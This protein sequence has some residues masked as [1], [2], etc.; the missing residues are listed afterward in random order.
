MNLEDLGE[1]ALIERIR[2]QIGEHGEGV[3]IGIGDDAA[4]LSPSPGRLLLATTDMLVEGVDFKRSYA[5][6]RQIGWKALA[7]NLSD[8]AAMGGLPR[9]ALVSLGLPETTP[10][11][12]VDELYEGLTAIAKAH[13]VHIVGGD[14]GVAPVLTLSITLIGEVEPGRLVRRSGARV[15]DVLAVTGSLGASA[16]G[17]AILNRGKGDFDE[18][19]ELIHAH[20]RPSPRVIEGAI[21]ARLGVHAMIDL[22]D[23]LATD[24]DH[25]CRASGVGGRVCLSQLP[26][27][28]GVARAAAALGAEPWRLAVSGGEDFE[29]LFALPSH[30]VPGWLVELERETGT[31]A[32]AIGEVVDAGMRVQ[33]VN[34]QGESV[35]FGRGFEHFSQRV[36]H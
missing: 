24:L 6:P 7:V 35:V 2:R 27:P 18:W 20:L 11:E 26:I 14:T 31:K 30:H 1:R 10:V 36:G 21:L 17:L 23:G 3:V 13:R 32:T 12:E 15:G 5:S 19:K 34:A 4:A 33:F 9:Y 16:A 8:I 29:L 22:S 25:L 28:E